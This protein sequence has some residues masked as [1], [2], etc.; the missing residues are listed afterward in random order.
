VSGQ[1]V[2]APAAESA[3]TFDALDRTTPRRTV[4]GF[5]RAFER[6]DYSAATQYLDLRDLPPRYRDLEATTL[7]RQLGIVFSREVWINPSEISDEPAG[8]MADGLPPDQDRLAVFTVDTGDV[9]LLLQ[10]TPREDGELIW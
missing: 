9:A 1:D 4:G 8:A 6:G 7:A 2:P 10:R 5:M 3:A